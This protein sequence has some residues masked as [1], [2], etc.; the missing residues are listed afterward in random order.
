MLGIG[1]AV[2][3][4]A[5]GLASAFGLGQNNSAASDL[6]DAMTRA[7]NANK[8][9]YQS[10][11]SLADSQRLDTVGA[12][13]S[14]YAQLFNANDSLNLNAPLARNAAATQ[15]AVGGANQAMAGRGLYNSTAAANAAIGAQREGNLRAEEIQNQATNVGMG[16]R[17]RYSGG[18]QNAIG[19]YYNTL[20]GTM[21]NVQNQSPNIS[22][23]A[24]LMAQQGN[25]YGSALSS[26]SGAAGSI[27]STLNQNSLNNTIS[28]YY[29]SKTPAAKPGPW[30]SGYVTG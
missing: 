30:A 2:G 9:Q 15:A 16:I 8:K 24:S 10:L 26:L 21:S 6:K 18:L 3:S 7:N 12:L 5:G 1:G 27:G 23:Y 13:N 4:A 11:L 17:E 14:Q 19:N 29:K 28:D 20:G 22:A 25:P